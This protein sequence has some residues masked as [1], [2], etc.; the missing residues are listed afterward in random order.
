MDMNELTFITGNKAKVA[1]VGRYFDLPFQHRE[2]DLPEIQSLDLEEIVGAKVMAAYK[3]V[4]APVFVE[5]VSLVFHV[6][7]KLPGPLI[8]WF[9]LEL[10]NEGLC[11]LLNGYNSRLATATVI[12]GY[13][14]GIE[15]KMFSGSMNGVISES[16]RGI[17]AFGWD[18][19][20]IPEGYQETWSELAIE[21]RDKISMRVQALGKLRSYLVG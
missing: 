14:D 6:L 2:V 3:V 21:K 16:P 19:I 5:D 9:L 18:P 7:G 13:Y 12:Y 17:R 10:G 20:F 4:G 8:K 11:R 15:V 1:V